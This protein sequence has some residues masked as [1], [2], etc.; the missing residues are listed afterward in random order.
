MGEK[1]NLH[2]LTGE[3]GAPVRDLA[4]R[5]RILETTLR[6]LSRVGYAKATVGGIAQE[7]GVGKATVYRSWPHKAA[8]TLDAVRTRL[9]DIPVD[10][11]GDSPREIL[12][13]AQALAGLYGAPQVRAILPALI[14]DAATDPELA[15]RLR[16]ELVEP[17]R[18]RSATVLRRAITRGVLPADTDVLT[19]LDM[20]AGLMLF[21]GVMLDGGL[22]ERGVQALVSAALASPPRTP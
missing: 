11:L 5:E 8:L 4:A 22:D 9:P 14:S 1:R 17:R 2:P 7:A 18:A 13:V 15:H 10:D 3:Q 6:V 20:W 21:R 16:T 19:L 12:A